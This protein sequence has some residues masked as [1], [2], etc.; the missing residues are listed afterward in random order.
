MNAVSVANTQFSGDSNDVTAADRLHFNVM[1]QV[2]DCEF[3]FDSMKLIS[4]CL[5]HN[6]W[7]ENK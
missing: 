1:A 2:S 7:T 5:K 4:I 3:D 6:F